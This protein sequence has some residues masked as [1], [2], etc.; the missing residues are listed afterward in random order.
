MTKLETLHTMRQEIDD[1]RAIRDRYESQNRLGM[2]T[3]HKVETDLALSD[4]W[5]K[6]VTKLEAYELAIKDYT[7]HGEG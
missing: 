4:I 3:E 6:L 5:E 2:T 7:K 1:L